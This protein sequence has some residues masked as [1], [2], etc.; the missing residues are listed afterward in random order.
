MSNFWDLINIEDFEKRNSFIEERWKITFYCKTC[1]CIVDTNRPK[2]NWYVFICKIC[3][4]KN[5]AIWT[6]EWVKEK[7]KIK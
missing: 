6:E 7:Y 3:N 5:I 4:W 2:A 1:Q